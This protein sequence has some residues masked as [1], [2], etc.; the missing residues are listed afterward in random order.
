MP[1]VEEKFYVTVPTYRGYIQ[2]LQMYAPIVSPLQVTKSQVQQMLLNGVPV[3]LYDP[4]TKGSRPV[5][6]QEF[7]GV[8][9]PEAQQ[10]KKVDPPQETK[11]IT[12]THIT[13]P[14]VEDVP[15][16]EETTQTASETHTETTDEEPGEITEK[17][18][19]NSETE[20]Q[21]ET[22]EDAEPATSADNTENADDT[23]E[24]TDGAD[25]P[26]TQTEDGTDA[27]VD[28]DADTTEEDAEETSADSDEVIDESTIDWSKLSKNQ[29]KRMRQKLD[30]Q[31][32]KQAE[33]PAAE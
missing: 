31:K 26:E 16:S 7:V 18:A 17:Q 28:E 22:T 20:T 12:G 6:I 10:P 8:A 4:A 29:K 33:T 23:T 14:A 24:D 25:V 19:D 1:M 9:A 32:A 15:K 13:T 3:Y 11:P 5:T 21:D 30:A 2:A 27:T